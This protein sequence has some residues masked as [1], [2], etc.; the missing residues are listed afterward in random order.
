MKNVLILG[1]GRSGTSLAAGCLASAGYYM[2][3]RL[4]DPRDANPKGFYESVEINEI[5]EEILS[6][7]TRP[8]PPY[9]RGRFL[10]RHRPLHMQRWLARISPKVDI[11]ASED[12][13]RKIRQM[14]GHKPFCYKDPRFSYTLPAW[15]P[16]LDE[17]E[18]VF[19]CVFRDP[20]TTAESILKECRSFPPLA[21][22]HSGI[23]MT[24]KRALDVWFKMS[25]HILRQADS[26][27]WLF[28]H[29]EQLFTPEG[30]DRLEDVTGASVDRQFPT[31][32]LSR[33]T[34]ARPVPA[35]IMK[36]YR[37]LCRRAGL[38][39]GGRFQ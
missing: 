21:D 33:T 1:S 4:L 29:Y 38:S 3:D 32:S 26:G 35:G 2:G 11:R 18:T 39:A 30:L 13:S 9:G 17:R 5:N 37:E 6:C 22:Y 20:A 28:L 12:V 14:V 36:I 8:R 16:F 19:I 7:Y 10:F 25:S 23:A 34:D 24:R 15:R 31:R 27:T